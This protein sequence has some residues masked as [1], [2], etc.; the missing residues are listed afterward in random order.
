MGYLKAHVQYN[1]HVNSSF[2]IID[3]NMAVLLHEGVDKVVDELKKFLNCPQPCFAATTWKLSPFTRHF[4]LWVYPFPMTYHYWID[5][6]ESSTSV[7]PE[8]TTMHINKE[9]MGE[10]AVKKLIE[11]MN[12]QES[13]DEKIV[14]PVTLI[15]RQSVKRIG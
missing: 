2:S 13:M 3:K 5:D 8:L 15:E 1:L 12:G 11:K 10:R 4:R 14:L 7:S 9:A 6:I